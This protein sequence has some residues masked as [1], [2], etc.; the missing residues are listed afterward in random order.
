MISTDVPI[1]QDPILTPSPDQPQGETG[2]WIKDL[3]AG[4]RTFATRLA[5]RQ[6]QMSIAAGPPRLDST[7]RLIAWP[8]PGQCGPRPGP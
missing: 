4:H 1:G 2:Q 3:A 7:A 5:D 8:W 6:S